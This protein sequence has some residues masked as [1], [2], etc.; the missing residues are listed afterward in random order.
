MLARGR[1][2]SYPGSTGPTN[3]FPPLLRG[4][5]RA[6]ASEER[7]L[8]VSMMVE[9]LLYGRNE[10]SLAEIA[11]A[12]GRDKSTVHYHL[13]QLNSV[14]LVKQRLART[15]NGGRAVKYSLTP[16][17]VKFLNGLLEAFFEKPRTRPPRLLQIYREVSP[18]GEYQRIAPTPGLL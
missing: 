12:L 16:F 10:F 8:I 4:I 2:N 5:L 3:I 7:Q 6:L 1:G 14:G 11:E 17:A 18:M 13:A 15:S 9:G